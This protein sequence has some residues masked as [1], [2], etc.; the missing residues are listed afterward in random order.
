[1]NYQKILGI[2]VCILCITFVSAN[3]VK[4][5]T[6]ADTPHIEAEFANADI[7]FAGKVTRLSHAND[8]VKFQVS[9]VWKG[10]LYE[11]SSLIVVVCILVL[12]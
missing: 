7:V 2:L 5:C 11:T 10:H 6:C 1:M 3:C 12:M 9:R 4:G 8:T